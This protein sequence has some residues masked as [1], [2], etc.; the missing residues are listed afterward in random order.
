MTGKRPTRARLGRRVPLRGDADAVHAVEHLGDVRRQLVVLRAIAPA[1]GPLGPVTNLVEDRRRRV[2]LVPADREIRDVPAALA[3]ALTVNAT[4]HK[5]LTELEC[6]VEIREGGGGAR[7][8]RGTPRARAKQAR[9]T[10]PGWLFFVRER[11]GM[12][13]AVRKRG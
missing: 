2:E 5:G 10:W 13:G 6:V 3:H 12:Q 1:Q 7:Q 4:L 8:R 11:A 9:G